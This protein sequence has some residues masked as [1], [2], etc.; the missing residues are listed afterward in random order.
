MKIEEKEKIEIDFWKNSTE[1]NPS[2]FSIPNLINKFKEIDIFYD[3]IIIHKKIWDKSNKVLE[4]GGGQG[5]ASCLLQHFYPKKSI[6]SSDISEHA[7]A[8][9]KIW[10]NLFSVK[11]SDSFAAKSYNLPIE[12][13]SV[14]TIFC[15]AAAHHFVKHKKT[16]EEL[17][18]VLIPGGTIVYLY[19]PVC[20]SYIYKLAKRRVNK[21]RHVVP[22][23]L[24]IISKLKTISEELDLNFDLKYSP[25]VKNRS[26]FGS[27][28][29]TIL[30]KIKPLQIIFPCTA[31]LIFTKR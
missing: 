9:Q 13:E 27:L 20:K 10:E 24:L 15:F 2:V 29:Y 4:I 26:L 7:V 18:R 19:E 11:L 31:D 3:K 6:I 16:L 1:E 28:Y 17:K 21:K 8:G 5:W 12:N 30:S 25:S 23:D 22:E 14:D